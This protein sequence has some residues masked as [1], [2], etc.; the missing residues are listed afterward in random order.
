[1]VSPKAGS[2]RRASAAGAAVQPIKIP[3]LSFIAELE[4]KYA[5]LAKKAVA[6]ADKAGKGSQSK[7]QL[8]QV[9]DAIKAAAFDVLRTYAVEVEAV[10]D[11]KYCLY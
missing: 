5:S 10:E 8:Q 3:R 7:Q 2:K 9:L 11:G 6:A 1:M 4:D